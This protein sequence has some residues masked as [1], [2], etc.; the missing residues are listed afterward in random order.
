MTRPTRKHEEIYRVGQLQRALAGRL[1]GT[2][3][4]A[5]EPD[6]I[7]IG[8]T[9]R[10]GIEVTELHQHSEKGR[11]S[12][13]QQ[14]SERAGIVRRACEIAAGWSVPIVDVAVHFNDSQEIAKKD[15]EE[16]ASAIVKLVSEHMPASESSYSLQLWREGYKVPW[17]RAIRIY[18]TKIL[19]KHHWWSSES[20]WVQ[21]DFIQ[22]LQEAIDEKN[23]KHARYRERCD[24]CWLLVTASGGR[25]SGFFEL[26]AGTQS[27]VYC[28]AFAKTFFLDVFGDEVVELS[29]TS[30]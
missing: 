11:G 20:G 28:S 6:V 22:E 8:Q 15:R 18:R 30:P 25:P 7:V 13:R 12:A 17:I 19:T 2:I 10:I 27:H 1:A 16:V 26:S 4:R 9:G 24:E 5:E 23:V 21:M 14:E 29:T 3:E